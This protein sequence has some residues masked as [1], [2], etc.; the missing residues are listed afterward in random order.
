MS[1]T[2]NMVR[3]VALSIATE[4]KE[5]P[6]HWIQRAYY[7][8]EGEACL[9]GHLQ[10]YRN[11]PVYTQVYDKLCQAANTDDALSSW[12]DAEGRTVQDVIAL[13]ERVASL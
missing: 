2:M 3:E 1:E 4:L 7:G 10:R 9:V 5:H 13:C 8:D 11:S 12:N 6:E